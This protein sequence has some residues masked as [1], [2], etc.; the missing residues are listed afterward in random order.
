[1]ESVQEARIQTNSFTAEYGWSTGNVYNVI[2]KSGSSSLPRGRVRVPSQF[3]PRF[4][5][6]LQ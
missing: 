2:T 3:R 6:L 4:Q 1:M 5:L